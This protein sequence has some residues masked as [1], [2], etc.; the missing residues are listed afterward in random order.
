[1]RRGDAV[2]IA[3]TGSGKSLTW[4]LPL[5][6]RQ[7]GTSLVITPYTSLGLDGEASN[8]CAGITSTFIYSEKN[9]LEDFTRIAEGDMQVVYVCPE[10]LES[11][12]FARLLHSP[13]WRRRLSAVYIDEAHLIYETHHW[14]PSYSRLHLLRHILGDDIPF[15]GLSATCPE[16]YREA[17]VMFAG[18]RKDYTLI[19][20]GNHRPELSIIILPLLHD[21]S[22]F[23]DLAFVVPFGC[24]ISDIVKTLIYCDDLELLTKMMW[25]MYYRLASMGLPTHLVDIIHS[26]LSDQH[27]KLCLQ[28]FRSNKTKILLGSSKISA[29]MNFRGVRV[30][31][32]YVV[33][34][35]TPADASQR[36]GRGARG[37]G[38]K[39][40]GIFF[41]E[42][43]LM[44][45]GDEPKDADPGMVEFVQSTE[46]AEAI[47]DRHLGNP[48][49]APNPRRCCCNRCHPSLRPAQQYQW[50]SVNPAPSNSRPIAHATDEQC[51]EI[52]QELVRWRLKLW[53]DHWR[54]DWPSYGPKCL[55][56]DVDLNELAK[57]AGS[58]HCID[59]MLPFTHIV[60]WE[61]ISVPLFAALQA[62]RLQFS[63][64][65][66]PI[67]DTP[68]IQAPESISADT[69]RRPRK[70]QRAEILQ[71]GE[72][73]IQ[74]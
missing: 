38:E 73:I 31:I 72:T 14:R 18:F 27:Q 21:I 70:K 54:D 3:P 45:G 60:H 15:I 9:T 62:I 56:S 16:Q 59:D 8:D 22:S 20:L 23:Q 32:Q 57:H 67:D 19:N 1:M 49:R 17:L 24:R 10:M 29:G 44:P 71:P 66:P 53:R 63:V 48:P 61:D 58:L 11:P 65:P 69:G 35:I 4:I 13:T 2:V 33:R 12:S 64:V 36:L 52:Y 55:V 74:F 47:L 6:A 37:E 50:V 25:W 39:A 26:G 40:V 5:L 68:E 43:S 30:V 51:E 34:K 28:D 41:V 46:C 42:P 7:G